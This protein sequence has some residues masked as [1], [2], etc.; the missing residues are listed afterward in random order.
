[1]I[2]YFNSEKIINDIL[3]P[4]LR[5]QNIVEWLNA[6]LINTKTRNNS[7][8]SFQYDI[9]RAYSGIPSVMYVEFLLNTI[10]PITGGTI[11]ILDNSTTIIPSYVYDRTEYN[12]D[13]LYIYDRAEGFEPRF[14]YYERV[15]YLTVEFYI[16]IPSA[17]A[18][19][20]IETEIINLVER[21]RIFGSQYEIKYS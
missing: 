19:G 9:W 12:T 14:Y 3:T 2:N 4:T 21:L 18:G 7:F 20:S 15:E 11:R 1:M 17:Y 6:V 8:N 10:I 16:E 13:Q 5:K